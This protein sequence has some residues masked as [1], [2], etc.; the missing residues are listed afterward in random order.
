MCRVLAQRSAI[1]YWKE[2]ITTIDKPVRSLQD[3]VC[4]PIHRSRIWKLVVQESTRFESLLSISCPSANYFFLHETRINPQLAAMFEVINDVQVTSL[5]ENW[6]RVEDQI[7]ENDARM[8][9]TNQVQWTCNL[10]RC[11]FVAVVVWSEA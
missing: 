7:R 8:V 11:F 2:L 10:Q 6:T 9:Q 1:A 3:N 5:M 4:I